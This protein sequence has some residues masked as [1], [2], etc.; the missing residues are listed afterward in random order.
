VPKLI[1]SVKIVELEQG[2]TP[3]RVLS[4]RNL[5]SDGMQDIMRERGRMGEE[6]KTGRFV[7]RA[8]VG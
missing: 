2:E 3:M 1:D 5:P 7:V 8:I 6:D 4:I